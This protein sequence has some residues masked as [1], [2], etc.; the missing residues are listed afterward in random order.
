MVVLLAISGVSAFADETGDNGGSAHDVVIAE[1]TQ[2]PAVMFDPTATEVSLVDATA[3]LLSV[4]IPGRAVNSAPAELTA[5]AER[6]AAGVLLGVTALP[7]ATVASYDTE[8][9][10]QALISVQAADAAT[11]YTFPVTLP[12]GAHMQV[13]QDGAVSIY[14]ADGLI[15]GGF[16]VPW[17][18]DANGSEVA[19]GFSV[20]G[21]DLVQTIEHGP[22]TAYPVV[23]DPN[24]IWGWAVCV[25]AVAAVVAVNSNIAAKVVTLVR[26]FGSIKKA[27]Q[28]AYRA[29][30]QAPAGR[31]R[32]AVIT[33]IGTVGAELLGIGEIQ[34][35]CFG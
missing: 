12:D 3:G 24:S 27:M 15:L 14:S 6:E 20:E 25:G 8:A 32:D 11:R 17:A 34:S 13:E 16:E 31:K 26:R 21:N 35:K 19:T 30:R 23:A 7:S 10:F 4:E 22:G 33:S 2:G 28:I 1:G 29:Y 5:A 9:G 18:R